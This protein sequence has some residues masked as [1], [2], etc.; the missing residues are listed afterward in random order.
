[1]GIAAA[2]AGGAL[3]AGA[4]AGG[5]MC[6]ADAQEDANAQTIQQQKL[7]REQQLAL[8]RE[9]RGATGHAFL[10]YY[11][12]SA[13]A[14]LGADAS[15]RYLQMNQNA[16]SVKDE[17]ARLR[18]SVDAMRPAF[19]AGTGLV[20]DIFS[21][22]LTNQ[23]LANAAPVAAARTSAAQAGAEGVYAGLM[24]RINKMKAE[25]A[26]AGFSG[27]S[28][29]QDN[30]LAQATIAA[31]QEAARQVAQ[32]RLDNELAAQ[33]IKESG[34]DLAVR[35]LDVPMAR[36]RQA[37]QFDM[38]PD[39]ALVSAFKTRMGV[40]EPFRI[41]TAPPQQ[42]SP[43]SPVTAV[44]PMGQIIGQSAAGAIT[45]ATNAYVTSQQNK[46]MMDYLKSQQIQGAV[47]Q[48]PV[49]GTYTGNIA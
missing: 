49:V 34:I 35:S 45:G 44:P 12:G 18:E 21:G 31:R 27:S 10:P 13:E 42:L 26:R 17:A 1:M 8:Y 28:S 6:A 22:D 25:R 16:G 4:S 33:G 38:L 48:A 47:N 32:A 3:A 39:E 23:R 11:L 7:D 29:F 2:I 30:R 20:G 19:D 9:S 40:Y 14:N 41:G 37:A 46:A 24:E 15:A 36:A 5:S 43:L